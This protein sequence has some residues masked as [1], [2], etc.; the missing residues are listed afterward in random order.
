MIKKI[1]LIGMLGVIIAA[2]IYLFV[3]IKDEHKVHAKMYT[4]NAIEQLY[5]CMYTAIE[6]EFI[7]RAYKSE[8]PYEE[9]LSILKGGNEYEIKTVVVPDTTFQV[10]IKSG[11]LT[12]YLAIKQFIFKGIEPVN[13]HRLDSL[14]RREMKVKGI[15][16]KYIRLEYCDIK[17]NKVLSAYGE[18][19]DKH[20]AYIMEVL[21]IDILETV[22]VK[23]SVEVVTPTFKDALKADTW[24]FA[25]L[26]LVLVVLIFL[27]MIKR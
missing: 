9:W 6:Q 23:G 10:R 11:D 26:G 4:E 16:P 12:A 27:L 15:I 8:I 20:S 7:I 13:L 3:S 2:S 5:P 17:K 14:F 21:P 18:I 25:S 24:L 19:Q 22:G 1:V